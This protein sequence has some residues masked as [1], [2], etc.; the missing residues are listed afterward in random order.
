MKGW[1]VA[2]VAVGAVGVGG[3][4]VMLAMRPRSGG[5]ADAERIRQQAMREA[6]ELAKRRAEEEAAKRPKDMGMAGIFAN[7]STTATGMASQLFARSDVQNALAGG[8]TAGIGK[9]SSSDSTGGTQ[10]APPINY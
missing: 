3:G 7:I 9:L 2:L 6:E 1:M 4:L 10:D 8:I 5:A